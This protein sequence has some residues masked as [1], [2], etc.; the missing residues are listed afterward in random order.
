MF[1]C[2]LRN[3]ITVGDDAVNEAAAHGVLGLYYVGAIPRRDR[4]AIGLAASRVDLSGA[5]DAGARDET[6]YELFYKAELTAA[7]SLQLG[8]QYVDGVGGDREESATVLG[9]RMSVAL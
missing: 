5:E 6:I 8:I 7:T 3:S 4:D 2:K 1:R 9:L